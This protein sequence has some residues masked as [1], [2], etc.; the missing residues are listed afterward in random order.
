MPFGTCKYLQE[1]GQE[2]EKER[3][4]ETDRSIERQRERQSEGAWVIANAL[5]R[6]WTI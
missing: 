1:D 6:G 3:D 5:R 4:R 2:H